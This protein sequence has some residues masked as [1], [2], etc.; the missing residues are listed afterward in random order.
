MS[1]PPQERLP[2]S[3][4]LG[5]AA[6]EYSQAETEDEFTRARAKLYYAARRL[7]ARPKRRY[8]RRSGQF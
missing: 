7:G 6:A 1:F 5:A 3:E 2:P 4:R 8:I